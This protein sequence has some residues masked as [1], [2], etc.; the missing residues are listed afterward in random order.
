MM[1]EKN[2]SFRMKIMI[3][4]SIFALAILTMSILG[5][6]N[7]EKV[8]NVADGVAKVRLPGITSLLESRASLYR[9]LLAERTV[10]FTDVDSANY[11]ALVQQHTTNLD[12]VQE[13]TGYVKSILPEQRYQDGITNFEDM[14]KQWRKTTNEVVR[15]RS[16]DTRIGRNLAIDIS[17]HQSAQQFTELADTL[18]T[19]VDMSRVQ[20]ETMSM[21]SSILAET[22]L[23]LLTTFGAVTL[24]MCLFLVTVFPGIITKRLRNI[25]NM[26]ENIS[27][28]EGDLTKRLDDSGSDEIARIAQS[29]NEFINKIHSLV[30]DI[31][32]VSS[33]INL[34][35]NDIDAGN[36]DLSKRAESQAASLEETA[37]SME[38]M[39]VSVKQNADSAQQAMHLSNSA[40]KDAAK[41]GE[42]VQRTAA[43]MNDINGASSKIVDIIATIDGIAFQTN[44]LA[45]NAAVEAARAG[46]H[47]RGF[48]VVAAEVRSLSQRCSDAAKEIKVLIQDTTNK[49]KIGS[50]LVSESGATLEEIV[51]GVTKVAD[52]VAD[53]AAASHEQA[54]GIEQ[55][56]TAIVQM[57]NMTQQNAALMEQA[58]AASASMKDQTGILEHKVSSFIVDTDIDKKLKLASDTNKQVKYIESAKVKKS[59]AVSESGSK[60]ARRETISTQTKPDED[61]WVN[62]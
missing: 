37:T 41:G 34:S 53:I 33:S 32:E 62:F 4:M 14:F 38:E 11:S 52:I 7:I 24:V 49:V 54:S 9:T 3:P 47:G 44:L 56:N 59:A 60:T 17:A 29:Y 15:N 39:T 48:A 43:A 13:M 28:G 61:E 27:K 40:R 21:E 51:K 50:D 12:N 26:I 31:K 45:L 36:R 22:T 25:L 16:G 2:I 42:V 23:T 55:V 35:S 10:L 58:G 6:A 5:V 8:K 57:D 20:T 46:E 19:L 1:G 30:V 18:E